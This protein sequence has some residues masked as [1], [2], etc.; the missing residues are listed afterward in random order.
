MSIDPSTLDTG[1]ATFDPRLKGPDFLDVA[2]YPAM[3]FTSTAIKRS[4]LN[5]GTMTGNLMLHGMNSGPLTFNVTL[6]RRRPG[7]AAS[8]HGVLGHIGAGDEG[9]RHRYRRQ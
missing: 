9:L 2:K 5:H 1:Q 4:D 7:Q 6:Q 8:R 3:T